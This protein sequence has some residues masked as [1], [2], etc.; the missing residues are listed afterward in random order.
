[1]D[2]HGNGQL[3]AYSQPGESLAWRQRSQDSS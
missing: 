2:A 3:K 1:M